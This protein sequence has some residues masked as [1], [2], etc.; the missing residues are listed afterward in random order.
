MVLGQEELVDQVQ[1]TVLDTEAPT[2]KRRRHDDSPFTHDD[3][4]DPSSQ[5][6]TSFGSIIGGPGWQSDSPPIC[7]GG[8]HDEGDEGE[9]FHTP[10]PGGTPFYSPALSLGRASFGSY[11][12]DD[13][14]EA[15]PTKQAFTFADVD[16][17]HVGK[18]A[19]PQPAAEV[20]APENSDRGHGHPAAAL[21]AA[22]DDSADHAQHAWQHDVSAG[23]AG[24]D[25]SCN[26]A[27][28]DV[29][30][31]AHAE[32]MLPLLMHSRPVSISLADPPGPGKPAAS[33]FIHLAYMPMG[34]S[35][36]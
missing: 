35:V 25:G 29:D 20:A 36:L 10:G 15:A 6:A 30:E 22:A 19:E 32:V 14:S 9:I 1:A 17:P 7:M 27:G 12:G 26:A 28:S 34:R 2:P 8:L 3:S 33:Q 4:P 5:Q 11:L 13:A 21:Q 18:P 24:A 23:I 31:T 16:D